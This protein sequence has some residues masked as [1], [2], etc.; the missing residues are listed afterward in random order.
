MDQQVSVKD[1]TGVRLSLSTD[2]ETVGCLGWIL[3]DSWSL[4]VFTWEH[5]LSLLLL[6][7]AISCQISLTVNEPPR[8]SNFSRSFTL[9]NGSVVGVFLMNDL[10]WS[11]TVDAVLL[12][13]MLKSWRRYVDTS[14]GI[15]WLNCSSF[16]SCCIFLTGSSC[17]HKAV[18]RQIASCSLVTVYSTDWW[19]KWT[20][21]YAVDKM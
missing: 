8:P 9:I 2:G 18:C 14:V 19:W 10:E 6:G 21:S 16:S 20:L 11:Q 4:C 1:P 12:V 3:T 15:R 17:G 5:F 7:C 13:G